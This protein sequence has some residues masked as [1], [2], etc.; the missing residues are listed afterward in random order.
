MT[1]RKINS[2]V[3]RRFDTSSPGGMREWKHRISRGIWEFVKNNFPSKQPVSGHNFW[4]DSETVLNALVL[5]GYAFR[6]AEMKDFSAPVGQRTSTRKHPFYSKE[7]GWRMTE[8]RAMTG[9]LG[10]YQRETEYWGG[11]TIDPAL[12]F[13][14]VK[15]EGEVVAYGLDAEG[16]LPV[17]SY[18]V[19]LWLQENFSEV[20]RIIDDAYLEVFRVK[21][22]A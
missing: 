12:G 13:F 2:S 21:R 7:Y 5:E 9:R 19:C 10:C 15:K 20:Q 8:N 11:R 17:F 3:I 14:G 4:V 1:K 22:V 16:A 18:D 6:A